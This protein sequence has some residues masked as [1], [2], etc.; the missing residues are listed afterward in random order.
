MAT[1]TAQKP[2]KIKVGTILDSELYGRLRLR[3]AKEGRSI[4]TII[5]E[6]V[7]RYEQEE[8]LASEMRMRAL[9]SV[10]ALKFRVSDADF[11]TI[12]DEDYYDQ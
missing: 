10:F 2:K 8:A 11:R 9:E 4:S 7:L 12:M 1:R 6:A 5:E 3:S